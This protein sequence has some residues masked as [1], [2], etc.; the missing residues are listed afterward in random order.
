MKRFVKWVLRVALLLVVIAAVFLAL[1]TYL[2]YKPAEKE[3]LHTNSKVEPYSLDTLRLLTWNIGYAG[4]DSNM[5]FFMDGG[6]RMRQTEEK[7][8]E[9]LEAIISFLSD[10]QNVDFCLLQDVD[11]KSRRSYQI[12][13]LSA[14]AL[15]MQQHLAFFALH[16][17]AELVP[18][19]ISNPMEVVE[20]GIAVFSR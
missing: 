9:N 14:I 7:T 15:A 8:N 5:D 18:V 16:H 20:S 10:Y 2:E 11:I 17:Q 3:V 1:M 19:P 13:E 12:D 4:L 6:K